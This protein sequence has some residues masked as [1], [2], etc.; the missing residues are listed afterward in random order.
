VNEGRSG[1]E[2]ERIRA[3]AALRNVRSKQK[4]AAEQRGEMHFLSNEE[5]EKWIE[6]NVER[7]TAGAR[8]RVEDTEAAVHQE[9]RNM[10]HAEIAGL[11]TRKPKKTL[12][13]MLD[14]IGVS[15]SDVASSYHEEDV[16]DE[17]D[18]ETKQGMLSEDDEPGWVMGTITNRVQQLRERF[19]QKQMKLDELT[20]PEW[21]EPA[22]YFRE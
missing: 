19:R 8:K 18:A 9:Q 16:V 12:E 2:A 22:I 17:D 10:T 1:L 7:E 13:E 6:D 15:L 21:E 5:K 11:T 4:L 20:E 14:A 3:L